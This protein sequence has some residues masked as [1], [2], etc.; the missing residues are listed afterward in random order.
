MWTLEV[1]A[2]AGQPMHEE[3]G[4]AKIVLRGIYVR[5]LPWI[6]IKDEY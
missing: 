1:D 3:A 6:K 5:S 2:A 4:A